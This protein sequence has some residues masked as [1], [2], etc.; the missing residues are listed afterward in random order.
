MDNFIV[1]EG[2]SDWLN[3]Y[4]WEWFMT[5]TFN[6]R[7]SPAAGRRAIQ[8]FFKRL[9]KR[10]E[11]SIP[12]F[13]VQEYSMYGEGPH[14]HA[15]VGNVN[16]AADGHSAEIAWKIWTSGKGHGRMETQKYDARK[17]AGFYMGKYVIKDRCDKG[18]WDIDRFEVFEDGNANSRN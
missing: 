5:A 16:K 7:F 14:Y 18:D 10:F 15:L 2:L 1:R 17:G 13:W 8:R 11:R 12:R 6:G 3:T 4:P 9:E